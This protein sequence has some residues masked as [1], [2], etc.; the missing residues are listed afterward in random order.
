MWPYRDELRAGYE[1]VAAWPERWP[2]EID[3]FAAARGVRKADDVVAR[4]GT[5]DEAELLES[6]HRHA[7]AIDWFLRRAEDGRR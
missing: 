6:V 3:V 4:R 7:E 1:R 5:T 2:G